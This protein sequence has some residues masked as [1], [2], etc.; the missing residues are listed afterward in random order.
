MKYPVTLMMV[1]M[2]SCIILTGCKSE[3]KQSQTS[4]QQMP[5]TTVN[6]V[7]VQ[8]QSVPLTKK[9]S[10]RTVA[11]QEAVVLPQVTGIIDKQL[12]REGGFVKQGDALYQLNPD[13]YTSALAS[14]KANLA[15]A[16]AGVTTAKANYNN[17]IASLKS[18]QAELAL[19]QANLNRLEQLK[20]SKAI[21]KQEYDVGV[22]SVKTAQAAVENAEAQIGVAQAGIESAMAAVESA[23]QTINS[24]QL[25]IDRTIVKAPTSGITSRTS[26]NVGALATSGQ[27]QMVTISQ[28]NPIF[29]DINQSSAELLALRQEYM[30]GNVSSPNTAKVQLILADGSIYPTMGQLSFEEA[31]VDPNTGTINL[32]AVFP[33]DGF[34]LLPGML[35]N[36]QIIQGVIN[37]AVLLPQ[38]AINRTAKGET[39]VNIVDANSKIQVRPV[40][41]NGT[42]QGKWIITNGLKQGEQVVVTGGSGVKPNQKVVVKPANAPNPANSG[43]PMRP[44]SST[45]QTPMASTATNQPET[46]VSKPSVPSKP[47]TE[48]PTTDAVTNQP[49]DNANQQ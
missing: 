38:S 30:K 6:T 16:Q 24:H 42:Y 48:K 29:V 35:V 36:A 11:F 8:F 13:N 12:F 26:V 33:N 37:S 32:R 45:V 23:Q 41:I 5:P 20:N 22:T 25:N 2:M 3:T 10:G 7:P 21:S 39:T 18:R 27:T 19:A 4:A 49:I 34:I 31:K 47:S 46:A 28:I 9:L 43:I 44:A 17:A 1:S 40:T 15:Q 14:S